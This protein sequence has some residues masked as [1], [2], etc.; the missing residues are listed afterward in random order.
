VVVLIDLCDVPDERTSQTLAEF[1]S[2]VYILYDRHD[3]FYF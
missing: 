2:G 1:L 3:D